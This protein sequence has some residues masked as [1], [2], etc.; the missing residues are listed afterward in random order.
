MSHLG[1]VFIQFFGNK[2]IERPETGDTGVYVKQRDHHFVI[3]HRHEAQYIQYGR[4]VF[5]FVLIIDPFVGVGKVETYGLEF[6]LHHGIVFL[7]Y[8]PLDRVDHCQCIVTFNITGKKAERK[9]EQQA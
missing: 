9:K 3:D 1:I 5:H 8:I 6:L 7:F 4:T 2:H